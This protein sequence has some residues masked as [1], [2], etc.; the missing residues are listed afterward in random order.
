MS[1]L[2]QGIKS[3][4]MGACGANGA[5]GATLDTGLYRYSERHLFSRTAET[6]C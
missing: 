3:I 4:K 2:I 1:Y 6:K 5:M